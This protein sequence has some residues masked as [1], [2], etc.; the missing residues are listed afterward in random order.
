MY[1]AHQVQMLTAGER[2]IHSG[3][4]ITAGEEG[5]KRCFYTA[6]QTH[7]RSINGKVHANA[8]GRA[9]QQVN[10]GTFRKPDKRSAIRQ[11]SRVALRF[12]GLQR[13]TLSV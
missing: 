6:K 9:A 2:D 11:K 4:G 10:V 13:I 8:W 5:A 1:A 3:P 7:T 12:P